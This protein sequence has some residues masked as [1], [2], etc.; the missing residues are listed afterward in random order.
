MSKNG[1]DWSRSNWKKD[2]LHE[3]GRMGQYLISTI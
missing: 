2:V 1:S 3:Y